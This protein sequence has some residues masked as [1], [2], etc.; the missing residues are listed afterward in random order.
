MKISKY[1][2]GARRQNELMGGMRVKK[3]KNKSER[4]RME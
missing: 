4:G 3:T 2:Q 1:S